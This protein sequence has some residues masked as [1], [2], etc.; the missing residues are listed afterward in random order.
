MIC[1]AVLGQCVLDISW[2]ETITV[3]FVVPNMNNEDIEVILKLVGEGA[4]DVVAV[5]NIFAILLSCV[6]FD[7]DI[8][9][10]IV[11]LVEEWEIGNCSLGIG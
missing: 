3:I 2:A 1:G 8:R 6:A 11:G 5:G 4:D 9:N 7:G 10:G